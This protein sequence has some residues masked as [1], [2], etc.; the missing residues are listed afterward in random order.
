MPARFRHWPVDGWEFCC[1]AGDEIYQEALRHLDGYCFGKF[2]EFE[3]LFG[4]YRFGT[5]NHGYSKLAGFQILP[6]AANQTT[7]W[8]N[9]GVR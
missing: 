6:E 3:G 8:A 2:P 7:F 1:G 4:K 9:I 5:L